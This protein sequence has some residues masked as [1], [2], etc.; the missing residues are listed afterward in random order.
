MVRR[1]LLE[2]EP[3]DRAALAGHRCEVRDG[4]DRRYGRQP[5]GRDAVPIEQ[6]RGELV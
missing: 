5:I 3:D 2:A 6:R 4:A 1:Q